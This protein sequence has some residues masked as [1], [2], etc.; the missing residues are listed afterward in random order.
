MITLFNDIVTI[1]AAVLA[2]A[3]VGYLLFALIK[4]ESF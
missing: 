4:P 2:I 1:I 3:A